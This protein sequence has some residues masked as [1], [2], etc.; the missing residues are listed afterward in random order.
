MSDGSV[1]KPTRLSS[2]QWL[3]KCFAVAEP[4]ILITR[5]GHWLIPP[6]FSF[7][8][9]LSLSVPFFQNPDKGLGCAENSPVSLERARSCTKWEFSCI[10]DHIK[11]D[12]GDC[13]A[14]QSNIRLLKRWQNAPRT[15]GTIK[16]NYEMIKY[17]TKLKMNER[18][19]WLI[20]WVLIQVLI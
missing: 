8:S 17:K 3:Q 16:I 9:L 6:S 5:R 20:R 7:L 13:L 10:P 11:S 2:D 14:I 18:D 19:I 15:K 1:A 4:E 12:F